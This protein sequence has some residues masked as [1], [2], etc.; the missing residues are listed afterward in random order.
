M[1]PK[2]KK[3]RNPPATEIRRLIAAFGDPSIDERHNAVAGLA[4]CGEPAVAALIRFLAEA[5]DTDQRWYAA[6]TFSKIGGPAVI[7][8]ITAMKEN[9][10]KEFRRY[11]AAALGGMGGPAVEPLIDAMGSDDRGV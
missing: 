3:T 9:M 1:N 10:D 2:S 6:V 8:V 11:A 5:Q 4:A 7:P